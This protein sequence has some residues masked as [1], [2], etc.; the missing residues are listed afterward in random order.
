MTKLEE[1]LIEL[2]YE[3][4]LNPSIS[5]VYFKKTIL[6]IFGVKIENGKIIQNEVRFLVKWMPFDNLQKVSNE[7]QK[8]LEILK[9]CE[10]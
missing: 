8:D 5:N 9:E 1:K 2:G 4:P 6:Y 10:E 7:V 3:K